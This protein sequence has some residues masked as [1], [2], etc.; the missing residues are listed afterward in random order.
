LWYLEAIF[1]MVLIFE[2]VRNDE[3]AIEHG[4]IM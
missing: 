4:K 1:K 2:V 3:D